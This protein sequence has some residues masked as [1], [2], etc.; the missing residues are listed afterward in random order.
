M[1]EPDTEKRISLAGVLTNAWVTENGKSP[2]LPMPPEVIPHSL[3]EK[4]SLFFP[5]TQC[6][7]SISPENARKPV[8]FTGYENETLAL[9]GLEYF[10]FCFYKRKWCSSKP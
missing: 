1:L 9:T 8:A 10:L 2:L 4:V 7:I 5:R 6:L 3:R